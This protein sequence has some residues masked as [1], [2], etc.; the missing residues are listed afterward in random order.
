[1]LIILCVFDTKLEISML[2]KTESC[3]SKG[4]KQTFRVKLGLKHL[5]VIDYEPFVVDNGQR[6]KIQDNLGNDSSMGS[7]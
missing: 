7:D 3:F 5:P 6:L 4:K 1:M 2:V